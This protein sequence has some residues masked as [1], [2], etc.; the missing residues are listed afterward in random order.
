MESKEK[1]QD[2]EHH[3][4]YSPQHP[5]SFCSGIQKRHQ[6]RIIRSAPNFVS[7][8]GSVGSGPRSD[9]DAAA[10][11]SWDKGDECLLETAALWK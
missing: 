5:A 11:D 7:R 3:G 9:A 2:A 1:H 4:H 10:E 8:T 6:L